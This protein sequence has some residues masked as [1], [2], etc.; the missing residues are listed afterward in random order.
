ML[1]CDDFNKI[2]HCINCRLVCSFER[3]KID[4]L[5]L[6][7]IP[8]MMSNNLLVIN[9]LY[10]F[11]FDGIKVI[12]IDDITAVYHGESESFLDEVLKNEQILL[13]NY[14]N[15]SLNINNLK[16]LMIQFLDK[17]LILEC[18]N[19]DNQTF[20]IGKITEIRELSL[21]FLN[22]NGLAIWDEVPIIIK[23]SSITCVTIKS[24]YLNIMSKY[25]KK[26]NVVD[27]VN[28]NSKTGDGSRPLKKSSI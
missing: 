21:K 16:D 19:N 11:E 2:K 12:K 13:P 1:N 20:F 9:E 24:R 26:D 10:D 25:V 6:Y 28:T 27:S 22:F 7:G 5:T 8:L 18:E 23:Y 15:V 4:D 17:F 3:N 14:Y